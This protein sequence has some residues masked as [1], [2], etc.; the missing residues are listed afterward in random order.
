M[1]CWYLMAYLTC[2]FL[3]VSDMRIKEINLSLC[4]PLGILALNRILKKFFFF[5][6]L[7]LSS[8]FSRLLLCLT[9]KLLVQIVE[10]IEIVAD[11]EWS[12]W[13]YDGIVWLTL[14]H[15]SMV[16]MRC[17]LLRRELDAQ[18]VLFALNIDNI[19]Y[20][21]M[22]AWKLG[23]FAVFLDL[24]SHSWVLHLRSSNST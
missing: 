19:S 20:Y 17:F 18:V 15:S 23:V 4:P 14:N 11:I 12:I 8:F 9:L 6:I 16:V 22:F 2:D 3:W 13:V 5:L 10:H 24:L 21:M 7:S 1:R